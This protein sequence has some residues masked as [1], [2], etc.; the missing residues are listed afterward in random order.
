[1]LRQAV[2]RTKV[3]LAQYQNTGFPR[4]FESIEKVLNFKIGFQDLEKVWKLAEIC[5]KYC[6]SWE[7]LN[8]K[9]I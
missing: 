2:S 6:K 7:I 3:L 4:G 9:E 1:V 8:G 5:M